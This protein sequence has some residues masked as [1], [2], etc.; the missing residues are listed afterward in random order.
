MLGY[1]NKYDDGDISFVEFMQ[2]VVANCFYCDQVPQ[3]RKAKLTDNHTEY[4]KQ[5]A[6]FF[7]NGLDRIDNALPHN[8]DNCIVSCTS[9]NRARN[10]QPISDFYNQIHSLLGNINN[11]RHV[12]MIVPDE[13]TIFG[14][15]YKNG[16]MKGGSFTCSITPLR[17][18]HHKAY[19]DAGLPFNKF[20]W[21][22]QQNCFYCCRPPSN[23]IKDKSGRVITYSGLD[24]LDSDIGHTVNNVVPCCKYCNY[25]KREK[26]LNEFKDWIIR[27]GNWFTKEKLHYLEKRLQDMHNHIYI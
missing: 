1:N 2:L 20:Y 8:K 9:C 25:A 4:Y 12:R 11:I 24:R 6:V 23:G 21:L 18:Q 14:L 26:T 16:M 3:E 17:R 10:D 15:M 13:S 7:R 5:N 22:S 19:M 27:I